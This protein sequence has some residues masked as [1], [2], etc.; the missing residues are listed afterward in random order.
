TGWEGT[1]GL[2]QHAKFMGFFGFSWE[3]LR[4]PLRALQTAGSTLPG[5]W[6]PFKVESVFSDAE[7]LYNRFKTLDVSPS[8]AKS[9]AEQYYVEES[10]KTWAN[11]RTTFVGITIKVFWAAA[12]GIWFIWPEVLMLTLRRFIAGQLIWMLFIN[13]SDFGVAAILSTG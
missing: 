7:L 6:N 12:L 4:H 10:V 1:K 5:S 8:L 11:F 9:L 2:W 3:T 13:N